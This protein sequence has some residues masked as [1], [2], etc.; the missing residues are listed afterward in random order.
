[1]CSAYVVIGVRNLLVAHHFTWHV[2]DLSFVINLIQIFG[3]IIF[4][5]EF[6]I[7]GYN[8]IDL[9]G[10]KFFIFD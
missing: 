2:R 1:M 8:S 6:L 3:E 10:A 7:V 5:G 9:W 4:Y